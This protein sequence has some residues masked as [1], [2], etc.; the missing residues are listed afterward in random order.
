MY[1]FQFQMASTRLILTVFFDFGL[2]KLLS[3]MSFSSLIFDV[4]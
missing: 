4:E 2:A 3:E 1:I